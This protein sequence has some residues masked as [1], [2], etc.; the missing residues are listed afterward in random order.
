MQPKTMPPLPAS[1]SASVDDAVIQR[2]IASIIGEICEGLASRLSIQPKAIVLT[3][4][5]ARGEGSVLATPNGFRVLGDME[6]MVVFP[7]GVNRGPLQE[8]LDRQAKQLKAELA[9]QEVDCD[10]EFRAITSEYFLALRPQLFGY[11]LLAHGRTVWGDA[12]ILSGIPKFPK[13]AIPR[14]DAWR[15]LNNRIIEQLESADRIPACDPNKLLQIYYQLIKCHI[16]LAT[17]LLVFAGKYE[18]TYAARSKALAKWASEAG[19]QPNLGFLRPLAEKVAACTAYKLDPNAAPNPLA[20]R[21]DA[22]EIEM[23]RNDLN[24]ALTDLVPL[25]REI[26]R[27]EAAAFSGAMGIQDASD[28]ALQSAV[29]RSQPIGEKFRGWAKLMLMP[30]TRKE[31]GYWSRFSRLVFR[32]SPRYLVYGV[33]AQLYFAMPLVLSDQPNSDDLAGLDSLLPVR[34]EENESERRMWW[35]LRGDVLKSWRVFLRTHFA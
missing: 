23:F 10:L 24:R 5:F 6:Y 3:G 12:S 13:E 4:S 29:L 27:W 7:M 26:W 2:K 25:V 16:D 19:A 30:T 8:F 15:M 9:S 1:I 22:R 31:K 14:W 35:R 11:E 21:T 17:T 33:A 28:R 34:F 32:G 20:V 18:S